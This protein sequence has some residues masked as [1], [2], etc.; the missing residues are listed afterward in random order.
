M[1]R[2]VFNIAAAM[3]LLLCLTACVFWLNP[4]RRGCAVYATAA[5]DKLPRNYGIC[6]L[7]WRLTLWK[8][9]RCW[10]RPGKEWFDDANHRWLFAGLAYY[11]YVSLNGTAADNQYVITIDLLWIAAVAALLPGIWCIQKIKSA[12]PLRQ[13][14]CRSC[15]H[16]LRGNVSGICPECGTTISSTAF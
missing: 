3:S 11:A 7:L 15:S 4:D 2:R 6:A 16:N 14:T 12:M 8:T 13:G 10:W 1:R 9:G 5:S